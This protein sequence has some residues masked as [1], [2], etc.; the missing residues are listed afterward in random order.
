MPKTHTVSF[1]E[2]D[3]LRQ[4]LFKHEMSY[5]ERWK[6]PTTSPALAKGTLWHVV[7]E[8]HYNAI[9]FHQRMVQDPPSKMA[10]AALRDEIVNTYLC[11]EGGRQ[12]EYQELVEWMYDGYVGHYGSDSG[13]RILGVEHAPVLWLP[14]PRGGRSNF[15]LKLKI[16]LVVRDP[17]G[18]VWI[19]DHKSGKDLPKDKE[20]EIDDQFGLYT[21]AMRRLGVDVFGSIHNAA[22]TQKNKDQTKHFQPL[23]ERFARK[24]MYRTDV[25]LERIAIEAYQAAK[26]AYAIP[27]GDA[28]RSPDSDR[29]RWRCDYTEACL[30]GRK[31]GDHR[32]F[33][34]D[35][36]F[37]QDFTRH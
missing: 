16:D 21:W 3:T 29:C 28:Q 34:E 6:S 20:L 17:R 14:T 35:L 11:D 27:I 30:F 5:K 13:W 26:R 19:V 23:E 25:E 9:A 4:C 37:V 36:G 1:S 2:I 24:H 33:L 15:K 12:T 22:R 8:H 7:M 18:R 31:G 10:M 32:Q